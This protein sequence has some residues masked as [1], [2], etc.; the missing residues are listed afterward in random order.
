MAI[1]ETIARLKVIL[2]LDTAAFSSGADT[3]EK[4]TAQLQKSMEQMGKRVGDVGKKMS[5]ALTAPLAAI[6]ASM[7]AASLQMVQTAETM[8]RSAQVAGEGFENFQ[9][10]AFGA[11]TVGIEAEKLGDIF[12]DVQ[13]KIGDFRATG[14]GGMADF[15]ENIAPKV[16]LTADAF[17]GL[18]G[19]DG[20]QLYYDSLVK[21][22]VSSDEMIF[23]LEA[24]ASDASMLIPLLNEGGRAFDELGKKAS[25]LSEADAAGFKDYALASKEFK[26]AI[27]QL[28][29]AI[30]NSGILTFIT[31]L[32]RRAADWVRW[33]AQV[34]PETV[35]WAISIG[36]V[37]AAIGPALVAVGTLTTVLSPLAAV[38]AT[39]VVPAL[40]AFGWQIAATAT[41]AGPAAAALQVLTVAFRG[42]MLATGVGLAI[43]ALA[44]A[45]YL[46]TR[47]SG[48]AVPAA[49]AYTQGLNAAKQAADAARAASDR[50][51]T[52]Q[53]K[54]RETA[55]RAAMA[56]RELAAQRLKAAQTNIIAAESEARAARAAAQL[57]EARERTAA[58]DPRLAPGIDRRGAETRKAQAEANVKAAQESVITLTAA[59]ADLDR[60]IA[61]AN[62][63]I[64][65]PKVAAGLNDVSKGAD[66]AAASAKAATDPLKE[67]MDE[68]FPVEADLRETYVKWD[69]LKKYFDEGRLSAERYSDAVAQ[70]W[71]NFLGLSNGLPDEKI[72]AVMGGETIDQMSKDVSDRFVDTM[73]KLAEKSQITKT[74][75]VKSFKDMA[76]ETAAALNRLASA[77]SSGG[78]FGILEAVIGLGTQ[79]GS[80]G[81]FGKSI[82]SSLNRPIGQNANGTSFWRGGP[83]WVG[84][85]GPELLNIPR[86][87]SITPNNDLRGMM[88]GGIA[89]IVP[90]PYFD[91]VVD[92]RVARAAPDIMEGSAKVTTSRLSR[93][94]TRR[95]R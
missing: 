13:D 24:I 37:T 7:T 25:V 63:P 12:K 52:A 81:L 44:G 39:R 30:A 26:A 60:A 22:G 90:S 20:L 43:A 87:A 28:T 38:I 16:G 41:M 56:Q 77:I 40:V 61:A 88:G 62:A 95:L 46:V 89:Q 15:F 27:Q 65:L 67:L 11:S 48:E 86:G 78:F 21:A 42:L 29:I 47:R 14:G 23:Y 59:K 45:I 72:K 18:S 68:I 84:E 69:R 82:Q 64:E 93:Q 8:K 35:R 10:L 3:A 57:A 71:R 17:K 19:K 85:R 53:G 36:A 80:F 55:L 54:E 70:L 1:S 34:S 91:V 33:A 2:G 31:D 32:V 74:I 94:Q 79:L 73:K 6:G 66:R 5:L 76:D 4:K 51:S 92:D 9:R 49:R 75:V 50:L 58:N 83:S